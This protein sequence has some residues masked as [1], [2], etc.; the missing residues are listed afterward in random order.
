[1]KKFFLIVL[2]LFIILPLCFSEDNTFDY[3]DY[4]WNYTGSGAGVIGGDGRS[5]SFLVYFNLADTE[6][7]DL[8]CKIGFS[9]LPF[10]KGSDIKGYDGNNLQMTW[11]RWNADK[12]VTLKASTYAYWHVVVEGNHTL[13]LKLTPSTGASVKCSYNQ[14]SDDTKGSS[15]ELDSSEAAKGKLVTFTKIGRH[16]GST[17]IDIEATVNTFSYTNDVLCTMTL[18]LETGT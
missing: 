12:T 3:H 16:Y 9:Q 15:F 10:I 5:R 1:M 6:R 4:D 2:M 14:Y 7:S 11:T 13:S 18:I 8:Y 17:L